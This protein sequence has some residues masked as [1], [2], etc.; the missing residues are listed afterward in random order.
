MP[1]LKK[2]DYVGNFT[3]LPNHLLQNRELSYE[4][5]GLLCELLSRPEDW[6]IYKTQ[7]IRSGFFKNN[8]RDVVNRIFRELRHFGYLYIH[9]VRT[10]DRRRIKDRV[11]FVSSEPFSLEEWRTY[12]EGLS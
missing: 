8:G 6:R 11:W 12:V 9:Y 3:I 1:I 5:R 10:E 2:R 7:L 4:A